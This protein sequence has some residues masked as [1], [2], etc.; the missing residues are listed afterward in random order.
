M[1]TLLLL[2]GSAGCGKSTWIEEHGLKPYTLAADDIRM[3]CSSPV[4]DAEGNEGINQSNDNF[5]WSTLFRLL[6]YRMQN[7]EFTV[8]DA[9]N[10]KTAEMNRYKDLCETYRYRIFCVDFTDIPIDEVKRRNKSRVGYKQVPEEAIDKMYS[11]FATQKIP[12]GITVIQPDEIDRIFM[13]KIDLSEYDSI[14]VIG[15]VHGCYTALREYLSE[16]KDNNFYIFLGDYIDRGIENA[17]VVNF[18]A[19]IRDRKNML[20]L[21]GNHEHWLWTWANGGICESKEFE[22]YTKT[23]LENAKVDKKVAR[24]LYRKFAQ[25]AWFDYRGTE[26]FVTHGG[27]SR[28]PENMLYVAT[29]Q[30]IHGVGTYKDGDHVDEMFVANTRDNQYQIHG[31]RNVKESSVRVNERCFNLEGRVEFGGCLRCVDIT[32]D[33]IIPVEIRNTV[34]KKVEELATGSGNNAADTKCSVGDMI[35]AMR[36]SRF[37]Q[38]KRYGNIS[39]FNFTRQAFYEKAWN[40]QTIKARGLYINIP[41]QKIVARSYDKFFSINERT[42]TK[43]EMLRNKLA[44]P[45]TAYVKENGFLGIVSYNNENDS[46][47]VTT[48]SS[49]DGIFADWLNNMLYE[50]C[51]DSALD[52]IKEYSKE[53]N[54]SFVFEC[55]DMVHDPHIIEYP[56]SRLY[57][58][59]IIYNDMEYKKVDFNELCSFAD[60]FGI[61]HKERAYVIETWSEFYDWYYKVLDEDY[62]YDGRDI[63][64]FVIEDSNGYMLKLKLTY[65]NFWKFMRGV[66]HET[67]RK[68]YIDPKRTSGL[69]TP[70]ANRFYGWIKGVVAVTEDKESL[71]SDICSLRR[72]FLG[73]DAGKEFRE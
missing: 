21:E 24:M 56:E 22:L 41:E 52:A 28:I 16:I 63:E 17:E 32:P 69:V 10:S 23:Q 1:R 61:R 58:L 5:V 27:L 46:L 9:T 43:L 6:E 53:H 51:S 44:F 59:D 45:V 48:K 73:S 19:S 3:M 68:G 54:V 72:M 29:R 31:H 37:I 39:S 20:M 65:Y 4:L 64:G 13:K 55:V 70:V 50:K 57:L 30:M 12:A 66:A 49:P 26:F 40:D 11:R 2:R 25:C 8:I 36:N 34:F 18:L 7:G 42:D 47:F 33:G 62:K 71:P 15:D 60:A 35:L 67:I 14:H 38:E